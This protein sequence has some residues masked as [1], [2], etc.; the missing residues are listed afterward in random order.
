MQLDDVDGL[1]I[2]TL[3][4][5]GLAILRGTGPFRRPIHPP[6]TEVIDE[7]GKDVVR[8]IMLTRK[9]DAV[10]EFDLEKVVEQTRDNPVFYV[11]YAHARCCSVLR[12][13][14]AEIEFQSAFGL[15]KHMIQRLKRHPEHIVFSERSRI[16]RLGVQISSQMPTRGKSPMKS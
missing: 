7:V 15:S 11:H 10:L 14:A 4:G 9:N 16:A 8:F 1:T 3:N 5:L 6:G 2:R 12:H 13:A